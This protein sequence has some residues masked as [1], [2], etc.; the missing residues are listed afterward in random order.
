MIPFNKAPIA[1]AVG[2]LLGQN[3]FD[4]LRKA[5][6][7]GYGTDM[8]A[9]TGGGAL[10]LQSLDKT[11]MAVIQENKHFALFNTLQK[12]NA[13]ATV[14]EWTEQSGI[15]GFPGGTT[16]TETGEIAQ[17]QGVYA[18]RVALVKYLMTRCQVSVVQSVQT[19]QVNSIDVENAN[20]TKR[21]LTDA[22]YLSFEG[23]SDVVETEFDGIY[24]QVLSLNSADHVVDAEG[25]SLDSIHSVMDAAATISKFGNFGQPTHI[26]YSKMTQADFDKGLHPSFRVA[27]DTNPS[28]LQLGAPVTGI[29]TSEGDIA[30]KSDVFIFD[31]DR[32]KPFSVLY[33][34]VVA[35]P[36][37]V[38][39]LPVS[40]AAV[41]DGSGGADSKWGAAH[42]GDYY[43]AVAGVSK[44]GHSA[45]VKSSQVTVAAGG[46]VT[47][48]ITKSTAGSETGY[49]I[50]RSRKNGTNADA[51]FRLI[52]RIAKAGDTTEF[53]DRNRDIPGTSK[54][55]VM[56]LAPSD[57]AITWRQLLPLTKFDLYPTVAAVIPWALLMFGYL[58]VTKR[59][60]IV[61]IKNVL[62]NGAQ[63]RPFG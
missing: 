36:A 16:N 31:E 56:N 11:L 29:R 46:K 23:D 59:Q 12:Q 1:S 40:G 58:R 20:G 10:R 8:A 26:F 17:D 50:Y 47:L 14:D 62:P 39:N 45:L 27:L 15:G 18:R 7:A 13:I 41:A 19:T 5:L 34:S 54:A 6:E 63:W 9:L 25:R 28:A 61:V 42:A 52:K 57:Q 51:D 53:V 35:A 44:D 2:G 43:Y 55:Y 3:E 38:A 33:P 30:T 49:A 22:E 60:H 32:Q 24:K 4:M 37:N 48:T 21:L